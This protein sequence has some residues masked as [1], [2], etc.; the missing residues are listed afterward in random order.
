MTRDLAFQDRATRSLYG[1]PLLLPVAD[2]MAIEHRQLKRRDTA[3]R[4][5][6]LRLQACRARHNLP[7]YPAHNALSDALATAEL[8]LAQLAGGASL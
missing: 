3:I 4:A 6:D 1:A 2:T 5:G 8:L 7:A